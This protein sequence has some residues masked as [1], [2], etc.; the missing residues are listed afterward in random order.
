M[1]VGLHTHTH[2]NS[3]DSFL[4]PDEAVDR[5]KE[6]GLEAVVMTEHDWAWDYDQWRE[7]A[8]RHEDIVVLRAMELNTEDGHVVC[9]GLH[10]YIFGMHRAAELAGHVWKRGG[11]MIAA[12]PYRRQ[13]PWRWDKA[14]DYAESLV[15]A[16]RN[17]LYRFVSAME[18]A[19][20]RGVLKENTFSLTL[21]S[22]MGMPGTGADDA[23][24]IKDLGKTATYFE[25]DIRT[26]EDLIAA[27]RSGRFWPIDRTGGTKIEDPL[28]HDV[29]S[30]IEHRWAEMLEIRRRRHAE[31]TPEFLGRPEDHPHIVGL[32]PA[33]R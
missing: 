33:Q 17:P 31:G 8:K 19:N 27:I 15:R 9:F 29:P 24:E 16:E 3:W 22:T 21:S 25:A 28:Y 5:A 4:T 32:S 26:E 30:D 12:H 7:L 1:L 14:E 18:V 2:P 11:V 13:M 10:E 6:V 23:H 20:G